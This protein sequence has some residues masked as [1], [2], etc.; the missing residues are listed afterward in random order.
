MKLTL[1]N[2]RELK[3]NTPSKLEKRAC[4][5][6]IDEWGS[7]SDKKNIFTDVLNYG[8]VSGMVGFLIY[9]FGSALGF[10]LSMVIMSGIRNRLKIAKLPKSFEGTPILYIAASILSLAFLGFKGL[11]K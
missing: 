8:C 6:V 11:I 5:Y 1:K 4:T 7:Y 10:L 2:I 9:A 3:H